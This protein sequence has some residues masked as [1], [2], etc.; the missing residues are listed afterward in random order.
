MATISTAW[1]LIS[2]FDIQTMGKLVL[3]EGQATCI[4]SQSDK[5]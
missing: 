2:L 3:P 1:V 4:E 5:R